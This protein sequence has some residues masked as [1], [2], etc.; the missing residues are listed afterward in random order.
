MTPLTKF[1]SH[2]MLEMITLLKDFQSTVHPISC[3]YSHTNHPFI[4]RKASVSSARNAAFQS[5]KNALY[6]DARKNA[7]SVVTEGVAYVYAPHS[8]CYHHRFFSLIL[9]LETNLKRESPK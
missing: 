1:G 2:R 4:E 8:Q 3:I 6:E 7:Q 9:T 5:K